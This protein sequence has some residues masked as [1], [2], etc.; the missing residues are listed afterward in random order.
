MSRYEKAS[1]QPRQLNEDG[2]P[3]SHLKRF[4]PAVLRLKNTNTHVIDDGTKH[5]FCFHL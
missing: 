2:P 3:I 1:H 5:P 4:L